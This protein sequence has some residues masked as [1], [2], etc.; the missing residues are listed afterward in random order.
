VP[1]SSGQ[2]TRALQPWRAAWKR[3][4]ALGLSLVTA[5]TL[6]AQQPAPPP[7]RPQDQPPPR[8]RTEANYVRVDV[9]PT[10]GG[11]P[12]QDLSV[13][14]FELL[15]NG[16]P[17]KIDAFEHIVISPAG[18]QSLR[19]EPD[20][21]R[22]GEQMAAN[23]RNRVFVVFLDTAHVPV[24]GSHAI[25]EPLIRLMD[26]ILGPDD[27]VAFMT[28]EMAASQVT[29]G[30]KTEVVAEMLRENWTWG[31]RHSIVPMDHREMEY[32][33]C[34][35]SPSQK[36]LVQ[37]MV[38]RRRERMVL[39]ALRDLVIYLGGVR[40]E[41]KAILT[42]SNGWVLYRPDQSLTNLRP[43]G[44]GATEAVPGR[45]PIGVDEHGTLRVGAARLREGDAVSQTAC[46][47]ERMHLA[48]IDNE[49]YFRDILDLANR[50]NA[51]FYPI[52]PRGLAV[53]DYPIGP[54]AP[55][56]IHVDMASL[57][58][59]I[60]TLRTLADN[61]DGLAVVNSN[62]LDRG[63]RR[64][65]DDLTSYYLLGYYSTNTKLDGGFRR[66]TVRVKRPGVEVRSRRGYRAPTAEEITAS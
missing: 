45:D 62:D 60:E 63:L 36:A 11:Q 58:T 34:Y 8:F 5:T 22:Q 65:A 4:A 57:S 59:R 46:D 29:F 37:Q 53:F 14:D 40:E 54:A 16:A 24:E 6:S 48:A 9:Y 43:I 50:N 26:R 32:E 35:S 33:R 18:P 19:R 66:I 49:D 64:I 13:G 61:T 47:R 28:P 42:V 27:L 17:Q 51:S 38:Q 52:D 31:A 12:V 55:P 3:T 15:E 21:V 2:S 7:D 10:A 25:K 44:P 20:S 23:P 1:H 30:R 56:P 39:D 41:R